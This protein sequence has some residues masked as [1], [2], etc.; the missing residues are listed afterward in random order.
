MRDGGA[1]WAAVSGVAQSRTR[2]K[3]LSSSSSSSSSSD[4]AT[5]KKLIP[6]HKLCLQFI[7][8]EEIPFIIQRLINMDHSIHFTEKTAKLV[9]FYAIHK[10]KRSKVCFIT[11][12][13][14]KNERKK[15][16]RMPSL[17]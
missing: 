1:W 2:L 8:A 16:E 6:F 15:R 12:D 14:S 9:L 10:H 7:S 5:L 3:R 13:K 4:S 17:R 11:M